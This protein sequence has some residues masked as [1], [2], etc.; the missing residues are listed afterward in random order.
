[1]GRLVIHG[2]RWRSR[3]I[4]FIDDTSVRPTPVRLRE[5]LFNWLGQDLSGLQCL[6]LFAGSGI[7]AFEALSRGAAGAAFVDNDPRAIIGVHRAV[8]DLQTENNTKIFRRDA[9]SFLR[10]FKDSSLHY[11]IVFLDPPFGMDS[12]LL[13]SILLLEKKL[14]FGSVVYVESPISVCLSNVWHLLKRKKVASVFG[15]LWRLGCRG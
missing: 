1:M 11:D 9:T 12:L 6:D 10:S 13:D 3:A 5:T 2:G 4:S 15:S 14:I 7:L 8:V